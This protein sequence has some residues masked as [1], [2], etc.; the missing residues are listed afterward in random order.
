MIATCPVNLTE[1]AI[2]LPAPYVPSASGEETDRASVVTPSG[3]MRTSW[4]PSSSYEATTACVLPFR[5]KTSTS[6]GPLSSSKP[7]SPSVA[8]PAASSVPLGWMRIS[9]MLLS[10]YEAT[11]AYALPPM[12]KASTSYGPARASKPRSP[13]VAEPAAERVPLGWMRT[14]WTPLSLCAATMAYA[15]PSISKVSTPMVPAS[16]SKPRT[17]SV[18]EPLKDSVPLGWMRISWTALP[19]HD[20]PMTYVLPPA[21]KAPRSHR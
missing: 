20:V 13:L 18:A 15:L 6:N 16:S 10:L 8:E 7:R 21:S 2:I 14:S 9:C 3:A 5:S 11:R 17:P 1:M 4:T 12:S 19:S